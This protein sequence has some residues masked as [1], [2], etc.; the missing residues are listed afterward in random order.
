MKETL[1]AITVMFIN[2]LNVL[3][4]LST[5]EINI[6]NFK[7][8]TISNKFVVEVCMELYVTQSSSVT[9]YL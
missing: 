2:I 9:S 5:E 7:N 6:V 1:F 4:M 3:N 8:I